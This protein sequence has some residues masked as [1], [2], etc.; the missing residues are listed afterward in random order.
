M[1]FTQIEKMCFYLQRLERQ[2]SDLNPKA[3]IDIDNELN[4]FF[5]KSYYSPTLNATRYF[6]GDEEV[7]DY[8]LQ[9][10]I[11]V[12]ISVL[13]GLLAQEDNYIKVREVLDFINEGK[14][15]EREYQSLQAYIAKIYF[16]FSDKIKFDAVIEN[17][18]K[19]S[20]KEPSSYNELIA[21]FGESGKKEIDYVVVTGII[22]KLKNYA[23]ELCA[24]KEATQSIPPTVFTI[25][26]SLSNNNEINIQVSIENAYKAIDDLGFA[27]AEREEINAKIKEIEDLMKNEKSRSKRWDKIGKIMNWLTDKTIQVA[28][29]ILPILT[30]AVK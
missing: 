22:N 1:T 27:K 26:N 10:D 28:G 9:D 25:N 13:E 7:Y 11:T 23:M 8:E 16:S 29:I 4:H 2:K 6:S 3:I 18:A 19:Q 21:H 17:I 12:M 5:Y 20:L 24:T 14:E 30:Q 15:I